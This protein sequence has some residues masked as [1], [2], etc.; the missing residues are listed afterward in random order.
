MIP[1]GLPQIEDRALDTAQRE[2]A[3]YQDRLKETRAHLNA[4]LMKL[5]Q[6]GQRFLNLAQWLEEM[7]KA[8][9]VRRHRRSDRA[10]KGT[11]LKKLQVR[12]D[13]FSKQSVTCHSCSY[14]L[15]SQPLLSYEMFFNPDLCLV[16]G[17]CV[18]K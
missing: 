6:M 11:Q 14:W 13:Q 8:A 7:E 5:K 3:A 4:T 12:E 10:T 15:H 9:T 2:W 18:C 17:E 1:W 16:V